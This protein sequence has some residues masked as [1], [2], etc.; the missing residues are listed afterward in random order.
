M[1]G[2]FGVCPGWRRPGT[3]CTAGG[4][5]GFAIRPLHGIDGL[6]RNSGEQQDNSD[7]SFADA[8]A[9]R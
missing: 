7:A 1:T 8:H 9:F 4:V 2:G 5:S 3:G 6:A